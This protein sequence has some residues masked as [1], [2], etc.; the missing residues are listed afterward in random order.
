MA[1]A[2]VDAAPFEQVAE[3]DDGDVIETDDLTVLVDKVSDTGVAF[4][5]EANE[6]NTLIFLR[7]LF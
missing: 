3:W 1:C 2:A 5:F 4:G 7:H 6:N